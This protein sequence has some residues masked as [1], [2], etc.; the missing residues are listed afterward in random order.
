M[1]LAL[2]VWAR[3]S[4]EVV[5]IVYT[6]WMLA[7]VLWP[8]WLGLA[9]LLRVVGPPATW[10]L[11]ANPYYVAYAPCSAPGTLGLWD[12][13]GFFAATLGLSAALAGL[14]VRRMRPVARRGFDGS[15]A[16]SPRLGLVGRVVRRLPGPSLDGSPVLW[17]EWHRSRPSPWVR[18]LA[19]GGVGSSGVACLV[20]AGMAWRFG[21]SNGP[22]GP[23]MVVGLCSLAVHLIFGLLIL[24]ATAATSMAEERQRGSL[25]L[26]AAT[27]MSTSTI[28]LGKWLGTLRPAA[29]LAIGPGILGIAL[30][31]ADRPGSPPSPPYDVRSLE[32]RLLIAGLLVATILIHGALIASVGVA[33]ATWIARE[34]RAIAASVA[35]AVMMGAGW[36]I[37]VG[38]VR[39]GGPRG[40][41]F[42][43]LSPIVAAWGLAM[44]LVDNP[45]L[46]T[47]FVGW[48]AFWD[49][50][51]LAMTV[52]LLWLTA[53]TFDGCL[54]RIAE[55]PRRPS[56][57]SDIVAVLAGLVIAAG[58]FG[59]LGVW[60]RGALDFM[61]HADSGVIMG[62][63]LVTVGFVLVS[64]LAASSM[65]PG[66]TEPVAGRRL[67][68]IRWWEAYRLVLLLAIGPALMAMAT[69]TSRMPIRTGTWV[70][71]L[72]GG[73]V[74]HFETHP[75]GVTYM[76][77]PIEGLNLRM[78]TEADLAAAGG[79]ET[80]SRA[81]AGLLRLAG[82]AIL[83]I[84]VH[85]A[86]FVGLGAMLGLLLSHR[87]T[88][89]IA[90]AGVV[91]FAT[92]AWPLC[93]LIFLGHPDYDWGLTL[94]SVIPA[95]CVPL[96]RM[97]RPDAV[98]GMSR[99]I[100]CWDIVMILAAVVAAG[101]ALV[102]VDRRSR[103]GAIESPAVP[104]VP[105]GIGPGVV[106]S[107]A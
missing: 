19:A 50:E 68:A 14:A 20:A 21:V 1:A 90:S 48:I 61:S 103:R 70:R 62:I 41:G 78:A 17:R 23:W 95:Y 31:T 26:L 69:A 30:A 33:A 42:L 83:V 49:V 102:I 79:L 56:V 11:L 3:K 72:P 87:G 51:C 55:G 27:P 99:W 22:P 88:A 10:A 86:A 60:N 35:F 106:R 38:A 89:I 73:T 39:V 59:A 44:N 63:L 57:L 18:A 43:G 45:Y 25:D 92:M 104:A 105:V 5:V 36:P 94:V 97:Y 16:G 84:L 9:H 71:T 65:S 13:A 67:F 58:V 80:P 28:V 77:K 93:F 4:H 32:N 107:R 46:L 34:G 98:G 24:S 29:I 52:G 54:G 40:D 7:L 100:V 76:W 6:F 2:S 66:A 47:P 15:R 75:T 53:R 37:L 8:I 64:A 96:F 12:Y 91:L 74:V 101:L 81:R 85:G 82:S